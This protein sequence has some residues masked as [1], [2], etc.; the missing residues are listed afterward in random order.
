MASR[1]ENQGTNPA[2]KSLHGV[3]EWDDQ[4]GIKGI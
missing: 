4:A 3:W 1:K 2:E